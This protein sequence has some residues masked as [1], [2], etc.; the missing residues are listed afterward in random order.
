MTAGPGRA[1]VATGHPLAAGAAAAVL[2]EGG[3][4]VD[5]AIAADAVM[6]VV[7]PMATGVGGDLL[8]MLVPQQGAPQA[9][10]G[11]GRAPLSLDP[12]QVA[13]L[14]GER[15]P[16]RHPLS[17]TTP[18]AVRGWHDLHA[19]HGRL[20]WRRLLREAIDVAAAGFPVAP[21][22]ARE[23][24]WFEPV[25]R[26]QPECAA[27]Y[28]AGAAPRAGETFRNPELAA[29]LEAIATDGP[30]AFYR[31]VPAQAAERAV[32][33]LGGVLSAEDFAAH[34]GEFVAPVAGS[35]RG[36]QVLQC[37]PNTH[38]V[39]VLHALAALEPLA[40]APEDPLTMVAAVQ[41]MKQAQ[42]FAART[43]ADPA[44]NTVCTVVV[45]AD[46]FA[47]TLMSSI[48]KRFGAGIVAPGCG[49]VLQNRGF[50]FSRPGH[51]N[52]PTP[53]KRPYHTVVPGAA[54]REG[55]LHAAFGVVGGAMQ[56]QGQVQLLLRIAAW[57]QG[58]QPAIDAPRWRLEGG[59]ELAIETGMP[60]A[61]RQALRAAGYTEPA[62]GELGGRS[63]FGGAQLVLR[64]PDGGLAGGSDRRKDGLVLVI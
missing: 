61:T 63:D 19:R 8:A 25:L 62:R 54:L 59:R 41:A 11:S 12:A 23:W 17:V 7:E 46:G 34:R 55:R 21:V 10:N 56:P 53:G 33:A 31:G 2:R 22:A 50:G 27:L 38:G 6:G 49:F 47:V 24:A 45:D 35:F 16:E 26:A 44:G 39:A 4:A 40:L 43:V 64:T 14:P 48:F 9:Y 60:Q 3:S 30:D 52:G 36:L 28:R 18:G 42:D 51:R 20:P 37:P 32:R 58:P 15:I 29:V 13:A 1:M 57:N 5:A